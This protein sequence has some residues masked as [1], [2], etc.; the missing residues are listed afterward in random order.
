VRAGKLKPGY[1][2]LLV[3]ATDSAGNKTTVRRA[4][5]R[6]RQRPVPAFTG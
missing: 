1:H 6:C 2:V 5:T 4:F 3:R